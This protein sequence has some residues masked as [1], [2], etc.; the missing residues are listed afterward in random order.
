AAPINTN[1]KNLS[2]SSKTSGGLFVNS[3][4]ILESLT[5]STPNENANIG[6][7]GGSLTFNSATR[8]LSMVGA[9]NFDLSFSNPKGHVVLGGLNI[10]TGN[11][12]LDVL[13]SITQSGVNRIIA[14]TAILDAGA[15][16]GATGA[17]LLTGVGEL[18]ATTT[19]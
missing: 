16:I 6:F 13:G 4:A 18:T 5:V 14:A 19:S 12:F 11:L 2:V 3:E 17:T 10:G 15:D 9:A 1:T 7:L 8:L